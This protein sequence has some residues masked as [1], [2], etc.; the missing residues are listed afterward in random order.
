M[1]VIQNRSA[2]RDALLALL[3]SV[4]C[5]PTAGWLYERLRKTH[6]KISRGTI[7]RNLQQLCENGLILRLQSTDKQEHYD[8]NT[9]PHAHFCCRRCGTVYDIEA[10]T[11]DF[12]GMV[13]D[14]GH[15]IEQT[16]L[17]FYGVCMA[18]TWQ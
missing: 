1:A 10:E 7:H 8:A 11:P 17:S 18:C 6:P 15:I 12:S 3:R 9:R 4:E 16:R 13:T 5:H 2:Q 14:G